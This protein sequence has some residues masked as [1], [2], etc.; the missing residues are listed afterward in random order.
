MVYDSARILDFLASEFPE[1]K[2]L[3]AD[4]AL[5]ASAGELAVGPG[6]EPGARGRGAGLRTSPPGLRGRDS[7]AS[8]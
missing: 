1:K 5:C 8:L 2:L 7:V 3:P 4:P 6:A